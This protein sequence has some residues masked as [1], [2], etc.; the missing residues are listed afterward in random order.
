MCSQQLLKDWYWFKGEENLQAEGYLLVEVS[1]K[2][3]SDLV[4]FLEEDNALSWEFQLCA[5]SC[6]VHEWTTRTVHVDQ[7]SLLQGDKMC[8]ENSLYQMQKPISH[9][10]LPDHQAANGRSLNNSNNSLC[11]ANK[12]YKSSNEANT[13]KES[14]SFFPVVLIPI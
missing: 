4:I 2:V 8:W 3:M 1:I 10:H 6:T 14:P 5:Q 12:P 7:I 9:N 11:E 13:L